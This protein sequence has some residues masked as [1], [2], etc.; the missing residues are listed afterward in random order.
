[1]AEKDGSI[2]MHKKKQTLKQNTIVCCW[3][4]VVC[5]RALFESVGPKGERQEMYLIWLRHNCFCLFVGLSVYIISNLFSPFLVTLDLDAQN[6]C[7]GHKC[8]GVIDNGLRW[9]RGVF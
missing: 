3:A 2:I 8:V 9:S 4:L 5:C 6:D 7:R 1:M